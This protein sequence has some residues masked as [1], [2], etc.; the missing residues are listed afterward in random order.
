MQ[1]YRALGRGEAERVVTIAAQA[2]ALGGRRRTLLASGWLVAEGQSGW[3]FVVLGLGVL[4]AAP[5]PSIGSTF[6]W[7]APGANVAE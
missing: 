1:R 4:G 2:A 7:R 5:D 3:G 6:F